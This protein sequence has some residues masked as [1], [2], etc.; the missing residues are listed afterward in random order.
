M[1]EGRAAKPRAMW[2]VI[3]IILT[4]HLTCAALRKDGR[5]LAAY[6]NSSCF[7]QF[8]SEFKLTTVFTYLAITT[9][10]SVQNQVKITQ[11]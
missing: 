5:L 11:D 3:C 10:A 9:R 2:T 7:S 6:T 4:F 8:P 1:C